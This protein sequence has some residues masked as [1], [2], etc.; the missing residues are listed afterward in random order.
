[1]GPDHGRQAVTGCICRGLPYRMCPVHGVHRGTLPEPVADIVR[2]KALHPLFPYPLTEPPSWLRQR[3][4]TPYDCGIPGHSG[5]TVLACRWESLA[6]EIPVEVC[7]CGT[8]RA[9]HP[10]GGGRCQR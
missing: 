4:D 2:L 3:P 7:C 8:P 1:M 5:C 9:P 6:P 10:R